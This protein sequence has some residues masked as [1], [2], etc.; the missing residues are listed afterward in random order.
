ML[1]ITPLR[2]VSQTAREMRRLSE[3]YRGDLLSY[4][5][6][7]PKELFSLVSAIPYIP[8]TE[9][10][11]FLKRPYYTLSGWGPGGDCDDKAIVIGAWASL[12]HF[13][14][15]FIGVSREVGM[16]LHH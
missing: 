9:S 6:L 5:T 3:T 16:P 7:T 10:V 13:P 4:I 12:R 8:D 1:N 15:R 2:S 14:Y 11:E